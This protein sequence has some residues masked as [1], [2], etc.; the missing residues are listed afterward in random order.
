MQIS[1][2]YSCDLLV[3]S[4]MTDNYKNSRQLQKAINILRNTCSVINR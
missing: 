3:N 2:H 1:V 4:T